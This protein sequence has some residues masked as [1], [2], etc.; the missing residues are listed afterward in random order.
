MAGDIDGVL[1]MFDV[2]DFKPGPKVKVHKGMI[3]AIK[4]FKGTDIC[5]TCGDDKHI[6]LWNMD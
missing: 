6:R 3:T 1:N 4:C 2:E 5:L